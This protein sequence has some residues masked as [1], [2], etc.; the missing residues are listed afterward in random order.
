MQRDCNNDKNK[1]PIGTR[2]LV[3]GTTKINICLTQNKGGEY[4]MKFS[5]KEY[6][7][8]LKALNQYAKTLDREKKEDKKTLEKIDQAQNAVIIIGTY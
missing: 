1:L 3:K 2:E 7:T 6:Y 5:S 4:I 8:I